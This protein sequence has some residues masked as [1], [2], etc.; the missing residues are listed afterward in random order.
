MIRGDGNK[1]STCR[2]YAMGE[3]CTQSDVCY[4]DQ[5]CARQ[6]W[7]NGK[8][9]TGEASNREHDRL[10]TCGYFSGSTVGMQKPLTGGIMTQFP[11]LSSR[12]ERI[13]YGQASADGE[14]LGIR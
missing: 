7:W 3:N 13:A 5:D 8:G 11:P 4:A 1:P 6:C 9:Y 2:N 14:P 10:K 12:V